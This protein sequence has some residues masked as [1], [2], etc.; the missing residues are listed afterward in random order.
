[1]QTDTFSVPSRG[2]FFRPIVIEIGVSKVTILAGA[3]VGFTRNLH[4]DVKLKTKIGGTG[5]D[6][7]K[8]EMD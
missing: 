5:C 1:L 3:L 4:G 7:V 8:F 2:I 6:L